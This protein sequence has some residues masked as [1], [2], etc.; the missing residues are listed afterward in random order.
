VPSY[1]P[2]LAPKGPLWP[3]HSIRTYTE[4]WGGLALPVHPVYPDSY[5]PGLIEDQIFSTDTALGFGGGDVAPMFIGSR[6][7]IFED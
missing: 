1:D 5:K 4:P 6:F 2:I 7:R 3:D